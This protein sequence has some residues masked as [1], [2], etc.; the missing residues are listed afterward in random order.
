MTTDLGASLAQMTRTAN[1][2]ADINRPLGNLAAVTQG[3][4]AVSKL[5]EGLATYNAAK[6]EASLLAEQARLAQKEIQYEAVQKQ[7]EVDRF[8]GEQTMAYLSSGVTLEGSPL[9]VLEETRRLG[10]QEVDAITARANA[11]ANLGQKK[12]SSTAGRGRNALLGAFAGAALGGAST[13]AIGRKLGMFGRPATSTSLGKLP[14]GVQS[15]LG[16]P[17]V[18]IA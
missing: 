8:A 4:S 2:A 17:S 12:A 6:S 11:V 9:Q 14:R 3:V 13:Y 15:S 1:V 7:R 5:L 10:K 18:G 16:Y